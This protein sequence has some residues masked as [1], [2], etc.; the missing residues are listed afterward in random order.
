L[1]AWVACMYQQL[2]AN[3]QHHKPFQAAGNIHGI[4]HTSGHI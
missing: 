4:Y 3:K 1:Q 2:Q